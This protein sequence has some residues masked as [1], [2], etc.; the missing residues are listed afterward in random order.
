MFNEELNYGFIT[1]SL[2]SPL[3]GLVVQKNSDGTFLIEF[4]DDSHYKKSKNEKKHFGLS[5]L[6]LDDYIGKKVE[7]SVKEYRI[8]SNVYDIK[9]I[10]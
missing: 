10:R 2:H 3:I 7:I 1:P 5:R 9:V 8:Y 6:E 4:D